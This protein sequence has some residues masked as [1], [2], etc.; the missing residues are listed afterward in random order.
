MIQPPAKGAAVFGPGI[1]GGAQPCMFF[2]HAPILRPG[3][4]ADTQATRAQIKID[5]PKM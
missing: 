3:H 2:R 4:R 5:L 1:L